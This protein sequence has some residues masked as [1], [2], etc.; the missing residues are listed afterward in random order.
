MHIKILQHNIDYNFFENDTL[1]IDECSIEHI[2]QMI[3][4][5]CNQGELNQ[6]DGHI[7][8]DYRGWWKINN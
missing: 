4:D 8:F 3:I 6:Y 7:D 2:E 1:E 5:G